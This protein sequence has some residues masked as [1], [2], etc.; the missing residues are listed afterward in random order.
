MHCGRKVKDEKVE[1]DDIEKDEDEDVQ[2]DYAEKENEKD[3]NV[4]R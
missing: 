2:M 4:A 3:D 1:D